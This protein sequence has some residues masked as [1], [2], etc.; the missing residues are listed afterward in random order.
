[1]AV[2]CRYTGGPDD[3][4]K[5]GRPVTLEVHDKH[6]SVAKS[7]TVDSKVIHSTEYCISVAW[8]YF[9]DVKKMTYSAR[10]LLPRHI[11]TKSL[12][13]RIRLIVRRLS[14]AAGP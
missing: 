8:Q 13:R 14:V 11:A 9:Q 1:M 2:T 4:V 10:V 7:Y 3:V 6:L 5:G 12:S